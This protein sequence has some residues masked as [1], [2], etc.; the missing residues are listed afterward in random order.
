MDVMDNRVKTVV[1]DA[2]DCIIALNEEACRRCRVNMEDIIEYNIYNCLRHEQAD[3]LSRAYSDVETFRNAA[4]YIG[5]DR[6]N[7][8]MDRYSNADVIIDTFCYTDEINRYKQELFSRM[9]NRIPKSNIRITTVGVSKHKDLSYAD[10]IVEDKFET[11]ESMAK[12][13][14]SVQA[15][16]IAKPWNREL[17]K[18]CGYRNVVLAETLNEAVD[19]VEGMLK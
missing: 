5:A 13:N 8:M 19:I 6:I 1:F 7:T 2:D 9:F 11:V 14:S 4:V 3:A 10:I 17:Y 12:V 16:L 15:V 18:K